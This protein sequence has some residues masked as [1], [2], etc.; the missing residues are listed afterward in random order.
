MIFFISLCI[1]LFA[2]YA[3]LLIFY[4]KAWSSI[5]YFNINADKTGGFSTRISVVIPV[6][7]EENNILGLLESLA[8]Q[9]Y[10][11]NLYQIIII[12]DHS[13]DN[14]WNLLQNF[15]HPNLS[16]I[17]SKLSDFSAGL[18]SPAYKKLAIET[19]IQLSSGDI[20]VTTD[21]DCIPAKDWLKTIASF[22]QKTGAK[23]IAAPVKISAGESILSIFQ[24]LDFI[25]LQG[26]TG[27]SVFKKFHSMCNGANLA[28]EKN[29]FHEVNGFRGIDNIPSGDDMLLMHKIY[30][31]YP[32]K[33][34]FLKNENA[35][36]S[37][38]AETNWKG[39]IHQRTR[40]ASKA[41]KYDDKRIFWVLLLV[42]VINLLF[43]I[44]AITSFWNYAY[45]ALL[46]TLLI[47]KTIIEYPFV[48][49]AAS[50]FQQEELMKYFPLLQPVH[51]IYTVFIGFLGK[52]GSYQWKGR[53]VVSRKL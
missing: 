40:W 7:N 50:F 29:V 13:T 27:A 12:D 45:F 22:Y 10:P 36:V 2:I 35:I 6:R 17:F 26:I 25:A 52:F 16:S 1:L 4:R 20:I 30:K 23:F 39:F 18:K 31:K 34:F 42:Y 8:V 21:A 3:F 49:S 5:P 37:T 43:L 33:I 48:K 46:I 51:I 44:L 47:A 24:T 38:A 28:Y 53:K 11:K 32:D 9:S 14:T 41:D 15:Y 19:G